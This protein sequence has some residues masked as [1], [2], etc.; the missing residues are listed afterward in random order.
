MAGNLDAFVSSL[1]TQQATALLT[2][3][4][5]D[6]Y[7]SSL[8]KTC[9]LLLGYKDITWS[10]HGKIIQTLEAES[11]RKLVCVPRGC[12][13]SSIAVVGY[14]LWQLI[15]NPNARIL[16][17]SELYSNSS[18]FLRELKAHMREDRVTSLFGEFYND[19]NWNEGEITIRQRTRPKKEASITCG[20]IGTTKVG[21]HYDIIIGDDYNSPKNTMTPEGRKKVIDHVRYNIS[22]LEPG[23]TYVF[24]AT[25]YHEEDVTG[26]ILRDL[27]GIS[28]DEAL[29][30]TA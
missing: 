19:K 29:K 7:R 22:I 24:T 15:R 1:P 6:S 10:T 26:W 27:V 18:T 8:Y 9:K 23:G 12:F 30:L 14:T 4:L 21:Q 13:K 28:I 3:E 17:D 2:S 11:T 5:A 25:R 20:G 16:I